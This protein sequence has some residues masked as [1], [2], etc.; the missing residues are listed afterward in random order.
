MA[1]ATVLNNENSSPVGVTAVKSMIEE[2]QSVGRYDSDFRVLPSNQLGGYGQYYSGSIYQLG[3]THRLQDGIDRITEG[4]AESMV[5]AFHQS[6]K[7]T[8]YIKKRLFSENFISDADLEASK[9]FFTL[10]AISETFCRSEREILREIFFSFDAKSM[11]DRELLRRHSLAQILYI[12]SEYE[13]TGCPAR[14]DDIDRCLVYPIY[15]YGVLRLDKNSVHPY[16]CPDKFQVCQSLWKQFCLQQYITQAIESLMYS[17]LETVG[18]ESGGLSLDELLLRLISQDFLSL[19]QEV[20]GNS[21]DRPW[22][23]LATFGLYEIPDENQSKHLQQEFSIGNRKSEVEILDI[24]KKSPASALTVCVLLLSCLYGK[25]R[26]IKNDIGCAYVMQHAGKELWM[27]SIIPYLDV[28]L[29]K[30]TTWAETLGVMI[31]WLIIN[32][33]DRIMYEKRR[34]DSC[35]LNRVEGKI[36]KEQDYDPR[37]RSSRHRNAASILHD[38]GF[39]DINS[40]MTM[41]LTSDGR[42]ILK[43]VLK[44]K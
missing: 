29:K 42:R 12:I 37:F 32:Q 21:C 8:P 18:A 14:F 43:E 20:A 38:L 10:D 39:V 2:G 6:I 9:Q 26:G 17:V 7:N 23:L 36:I 40:D 3:L 34:L 15:Y 22:Q 30:E 31:E 16:N 13:Q 11:T 33:H 1:I 41:S 4:R 35:W 44:T 24:K 19:I 27:G 28:W 25:W 5:N